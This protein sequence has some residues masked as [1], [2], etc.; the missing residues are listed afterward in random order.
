L[1][2][3]DLLRRIQALR[4]DGARRDSEGVFVA[5]G[6]H[7]VATALDSG[8]AIE[9]TVGSARLAEIGEGKALLARI[10][11]AGVAHV[12]VRDE[13]L[14]RLQ[15]ARS[16]QPVLALVRRPGTTIEQ[17]L[18]GHAGK[19]LVVIAHGVQDP[20][21]LGTIL[22][23]ALAAGATGAIVTGDAADL[24]HPRTVRATAGAIYRLPAVAAHAAEALAAL[25]RR[26]IEVVAADASRGEP[27]DTC[28]FRPPTAL[29]LGGEGAGIPPEWL[30]RA[31]RIVRVPMHAEVES[32]SVG[33]AAAVLLFE[34]AR[35]RRGA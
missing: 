13:E 31:T 18:D 20:G 26:A 12:E 3:R 32:L 33:A 21:N 4:K 8:A 29:L 16:P 28:D 23:T 25:E 24:H 9:L 6:L 10:G 1:S 17:V 7:L 15:D 30:A 27:Y 34:A 22:R 2:Q 35:Q 5:E 14:D 11:A 19:P